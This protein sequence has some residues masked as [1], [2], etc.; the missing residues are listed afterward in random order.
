M[1]D[2]EEVHNQNSY[3]FLSDGS[4]GESTFLRKDSFNLQCNKA[5]SCEEF[6]FDYE[7]NRF[8]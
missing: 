3:D 7:L 1:Q 6:N 2:Q 4:L 5:E 8:P